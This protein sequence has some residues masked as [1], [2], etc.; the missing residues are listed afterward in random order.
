MLSDRNPLLWPVET[1]ASWVREHRQPVDADNPFL[2]WEKLCSAVI[3]STLNTYRDS[4][5]RYQERLFKL[6]YDNAWMKTLF[7][8]NNQTASA[9]TEPVDPELEENEKEL[10]LKTMQRGGF[11]EAVVRIILAVA[12][13]DKS[14]DRQEYAVAH[15]II[16]TN[17][18]LKHLKPV[19]L[20]RLV[21]E[22]AGL[23]AYNQKEAIR[24][25]TKLLPRKADRIEAFEIA[26]SIAT[27]DMELDQ[28]EQDLLAEIQHTFKL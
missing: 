4:R 26:N 23:V 6:L 10:W 12:M 8:E 13:A 25:L 1:M 15:R 9:E 17:D 18:R 27:A 24:T 22:Q 5:D 14:Y 11:Q 16:Q 28:K 3:Q 7:P 20:K 2:K 19:E 21:K